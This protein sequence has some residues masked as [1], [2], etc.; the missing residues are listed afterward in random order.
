M[1]GEIDWNALPYLIELLAVEDA[2]EF[3]YCLQAIR[4]HQLRQLE[5][6]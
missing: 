2:V 1:G 6:D 5:N 4:E 3:I